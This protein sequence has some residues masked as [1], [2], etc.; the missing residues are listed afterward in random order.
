MRNPTVYVRKSN[1]TLHLQFL[2]DYIFANIHKNIIIN[3]LEKYISALAENGH[4]LLSGFY[5][6]DADDI[7][8]H[9]ETLGLTV[10]NSFSENNWTVLELV[11]R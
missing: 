8:K 5:T 7:S 9:A 4:I 3:D 6:E 10:V 2:Y 11:R 1:K